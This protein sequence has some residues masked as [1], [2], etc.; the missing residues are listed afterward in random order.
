MRIPLA[1]GHTEER[2]TNV[3]AGQC[4]NVYPCVNS[5]DSKNQLTLTNTQGLLRWVWLQGAEVRG[6]LRKDIYL[7]AVCGN[8]FYQISL[9]SGIK[10]ELGNLSSSTGKVWMEYNGNNQIMI[11]AN[12]QG[13]IYES[14]TFSLI[15]DTDFPGALAL[16]FLDQYGLVTEPD[17]GRLWNSN[18]NDFSEWTGTDYVTAEGNPDNLL[19]LLIDHREAWLFGEETTEV[20]KNSGDTDAVFQRLEGTIQEVGI[21]A[22]ASPAKKDN[23]IFWLDNSLQVRM[24]QGY[25]SRIISTPA[26]A[27]QISQLSR[28]DDARGMTFIQDGHAFYVLTFPEGNLTLAYDIGESVKAQRSLWHVKSSGVSEHKWNG[29]CAVEHN[30]I[31]Y[32]GDY[33]NGWIYKLDRNTYT[34]NLVHTRRVFTSQE[35][36]EP[37]ERRIL[38]HNELE[39]EVQSGT[40]QVGTGEDSN[41]EIMMQYSDDGGHT[42]SSEAWRAIGQIGEYANR[43]R[44]FQL[45]ASRNRIYKFAQLEGISAYLKVEKGTE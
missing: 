6:I 3:N 37:D 27:Y 26:I 14:G 11:V 8:K 20:F 35:V 24:A 18:L 25:T 42:W 13:Y 4:I 43:A 17:S 39:L 19:S 38:F 22:P 30:G 32:I 23:V 31:T 1:F 2:S 41:P 12:K 28:T 5:G 40:G 45:G 7:Y 44:W 29:N 9:S 36:Y 10:T 33:Q 15:A 34:D 16:G 21:N